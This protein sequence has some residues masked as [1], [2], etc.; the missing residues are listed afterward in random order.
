MLQIGDAVEW[1]HEDVRLAQ[2]S[3]P[4][5]YGPDVHLWHQDKY[6]RTALRLALWE[7]FHAPD[8][9]QALIDVVNRG[10]DTDTNAAVAGAM[11]G[12]WVGEPGI[13]ERWRFEVL[14]ALAETPGHLAN[15]YHPK[16]LVLL[17]GTPVDAAA[18]P[19]APV[20]TSWTG[21]GMIKG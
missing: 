21:M 11:Y 3:D 1:L 9:E 16:N 7:M 20:S 15:T 19:A 2:E 10:G 8:F 12:A 5:L 14:E 4:Q 18:R 13:P 6:V 17:A